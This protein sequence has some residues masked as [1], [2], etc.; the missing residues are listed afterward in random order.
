MRYYIYIDRDFL[1]SLFSVIDDSDFNIEVIEYSLKKSITSNNAIS[2]EPCVE[3]GCGL[4][5]SRKN[6]FEKNNTRFEKDEKFNK[7]KLGISYD[8]SKICN[9]ETQIRY[10]N[11]DDVSDIKN[12]NFYHNLCERIRSKVKETNSRIV[13]EIGYIKLYS[14]EKKF[15]FDENNNFF[16]IN[17][18][19]IW[20]DK[21]KLQ[22]ELKLLSQM[23]CEVKVI[24]YMMNCQNF[25]ENRI[26]KAIAIF[27]E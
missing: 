8:K 6:E 22:G 18:C 9:V 24:G 10:I 2:L 1:K 16:M 19:F 20:L 12:T 4:E 26:L 25:K 5:D 17:N 13:E 27:I 23:S 21:T 3:S 7:E 11:I 14:G 15:E